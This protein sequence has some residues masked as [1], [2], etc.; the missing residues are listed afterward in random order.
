MVDPNS[1]IQNAPGEKYYGVAVD[2]WENLAKCYGLTFNYSRMNYNEPG[3]ADEIVKAVARGDYDIAVAAVGLTKDR[4]QV[5]EF[6]QPYEDLTLLVVTQTG[7]TGEGPSLWSFT[8]PFQGSVWLMI[9]IGLMLGVTALSLFNWG[10]FNLH[11][12]HSVAENRAMRAE[13]EEGDW[14]AGLGWLN[15]G[16]RFAREWFHALW[17]FYTTGLQQGDLE[18]IGRSVE[19]Y[20]VWGAWIL[21]TAIVYSAYQGS[22]TAYLTTSLVKAGVVTGYESLTIGQSLAVRIGSDSEKYVLRTVPIGVRVTSV[23]AVADVI[24]LVA[25]GTVSAGVDD[26]TVIEYETSYNCRI[27]AVGNQFYPKGNSFLLQNLSPWSEVLS[28]GILDSM[29]SCAGTSANYY[30]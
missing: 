11:K 23:M 29:C 27:A 18:T 10:R 7:Y 28:Q 22:L 6:T 16:G 12:M 21:F 4:E 30:Q 9:L 19:N 8:E 1:T 15:H 26:S 5:V 14:W 20:L 13:V 24:E 3:N 2:I 17:Q 25:N